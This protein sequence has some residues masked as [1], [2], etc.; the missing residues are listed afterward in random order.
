MEFRRS[1]HRATFLKKALARF[2]VEASNG[3][4]FDMSDLVS[5]LTPDGKGSPD[6]KTF[7]DELSAAQV[8]VE[9]GGIPRPVQLFP[10][11][12]P[13]WIDVIVQD[14]Q[15][16]S[17]LTILERDFP[18]AMEKID[19]QSTAPLDDILEAT[20]LRLELHQATLVNGDPE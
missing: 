9:V 14:A 20:L 7:L 15:P 8:A 5:V 2:L 13:V 1:L 18:L 16:N 17:S 12:M 11:P 19:T 3:D 10:T 4:V 6:L